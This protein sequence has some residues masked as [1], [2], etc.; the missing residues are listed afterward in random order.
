M[1]GTG[2]RAPSVRLSGQC[3]CLGGEREYLVAEDREKR[4]R[5]RRRGRQEG[6]QRARPEKAPPEQVEEAPSPGPDEAPQPRSSRFSFRLRRRPG[7][8]K[9]R[10]AGKERSR[11]A[12]RTAA[13]GARNVSPMD[14]W[15]SGTA[16]THREQPIRRKGPAGLW[17]RITGFYF[18]PWVPVVAIIVVVFGILGALFI[19]R[20]AT[21]APRIAKDHWHVTY[22]YFVCGQVQPNFPTW[23]GGVHT[24]ADGIIHIHPF[25]PSEEGSGA[26]LVKWFEYGGGKLTQSE[27]RAPG[28][29]KSYKNGDACPDGRPGVVPI[30]VNGEKLD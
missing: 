30:S 19:T 5:G 17:S 23:E 21:G 8:G 12:E 6:H 22:K 18:P 1:S 9:A 2:R 14:F 7:G 25:T 29:A 24:H 27:V 4:R 16:R 10:E 11:P 15:R 28:S 13:A 3:R 26:R 20:S